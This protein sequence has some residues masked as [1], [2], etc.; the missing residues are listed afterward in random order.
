MDVPLQLPL[1]TQAK[2]K[3]QLRPG[4]GSQL[5]LTIL[6][7]KATSG[8]AKALAFRPSRARTSLLHGHFSKI[9]FLHYIYSMLYFG[10]FWNCCKTILQVAICGYFKKIGEC[11]LTD[12]KRTTFWHSCGVMS[13]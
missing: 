13:Q 1:H 2:A 11:N 12:E 4:F 9:F 3:P 10:F 6:K 7:A 8:Q 5:G